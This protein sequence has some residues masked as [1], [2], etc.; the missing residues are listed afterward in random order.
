MSA[1]VQF[2]PVFIPSN[3]AHAKRKAKQ[4]RRAFPRLTLS[5]AQQVTSEALGF[6]DW[7][8]LERA[9]QSGIPASPLDSQITASELA[10]RHRNQT[11]V[12]ARRLNISE[13]DAATYLPT[14]GLTRESRHGVAGSVNWPEPPADE[15]VDALVRTTTS[16]DPAA[17]SAVA[18]RRFARRSECRLAIVDRHWDVTEI[19]RRLDIRRLEI[20]RDSRKKRRGLS[21]F[22]P[23]PLESVLSSLDEIDAELTRWDASGA[24][25]LVAFSGAGVLDDVLVTTN[26]VNSVLDKLLPWLLAPIAEHN[27]ELSPCLSVDSALEPLLRTHVERLLRGLPERDAFRS[28]TQAVEWAVDPRRV[29]IVSR[30]FFEYDEAVV[31]YQHN[32]WRRHA[33]KS[34]EG[35][36]AVKQA[37]LAMDSRARAGTRGDGALVLQYLMPD[38]DWF[39]LALPKGSFKVL[40]PGFHDSAREFVRDNAARLYEFS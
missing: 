24:E 33:R 13:G 18:G 39:E 20:E 1:A 5:S 19:R 4:L 26:R 7:H 8:T 36:A 21:A 15:Q 16:P 2:A 23:H 32:R 30:R 3:I 11:V 34:S 28:G 25:F 9:V 14:W 40:P 38:D 31:G 12:L 29:Q 27:G 10:E 35:P 17:V 37:M 22:G 6:D